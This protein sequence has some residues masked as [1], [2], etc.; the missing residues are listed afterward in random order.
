M[1]AKKFLTLDAA[2]GMQLVQVNDYLDITQGGTGATTAAGA[3][4]ALGAYPASNPN[5]WTANLGTVTSVTASAPV[6]S[7]GGTTP[8]ISMPA[9]TTSVSGYLSAADWTTFNSK[10]AALG[11]VPTN[12]ALAGAANGY[13]TLDSSGK[14]PIGQITTAVL[15]ANVC[16]GSWNAATNV[17]ALATGV[18]TQGYYWIVGTAGTTNINGFNSWAV[19]DQILFANGNYIKIDGEATVVSLV[20]G[21]AGVVILTQADIGGLTTGSTPT[22]TGVNATTFTGALAGNAT[23]A[24]TAGNVSGIVA[25]ANGG[26]GAS[27]APAALTA[28]GAYPASNPNNYISANQ[29]ITFT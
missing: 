23:T 4:T 28:L 25:V 16:Q 9:A 7:T 26:T 6:Q 19:N 21:R 20:A 13:A 3:L 22:F 8:V 27:T 29:N 2:G 10:Q 17:P 18:G 14:I 15:G 11:F 24:T 12:S 1:A 5:N